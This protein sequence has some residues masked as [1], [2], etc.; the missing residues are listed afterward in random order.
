VYYGSI[1]TNGFKLTVRMGYIYMG[2]YAL[3][4]LYSIFLVWLVDI[5]GL[6]DKSTLRK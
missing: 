4:A 2:V 5:Y 3:Y 6:N 1:A